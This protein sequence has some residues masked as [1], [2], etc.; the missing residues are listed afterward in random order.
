MLKIYKDIEIQDKK[1]S[2]SGFLDFGI[3]KI[4][5][6]KCEY[7]VAKGNNSEIL[8]FDAVKLN[9]SGLEC[10]RINLD[11]DLILTDNV[12]SL[13]YLDVTKEFS[14]KLTKGIYYFEFTNSIS[15]FK[16]EIVEVVEFTVNVT[17]VID[18]I[19][20]N[21][22]KMYHDIDTRTTL[23]VLSPEIDTVEYSTDDG[24]SWHNAIGTL[25]FSKNT[26][27]WWRVSAYNT[28]IAGNMT[29]KG[30]QL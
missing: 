27:S 3:Q 29:L 23:I 13:Y 11:T 8:T 10:E 24:V 1:K 5:N 12:K 26:V 25:T 16:T 15:I 6:N 2:Y 14:E 28:G 18:F 22:Q 17:F 7:F 9:S 21:I 30:K 20:T 19:S 4:L